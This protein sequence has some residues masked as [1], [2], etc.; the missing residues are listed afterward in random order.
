MLY[1]RKL[2]V[3]IL[4]LYSNNKTFYYIINNEQHYSMYWQVLDSTTPWEN[5][6][7]R[8]I[9]NF[10]T[11]YMVLCF[12]LFYLKNY[13]MVSLYS[14]CTVS[15][16][17][18]CFISGQYGISRRFYFPFQKSYWCGRSSSHDRSDEYL[19]QG[20]TIELRGQGKAF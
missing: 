6:K 3:A 7:E 15:L 13:I 19:Y 17:I 20:S 1:I 14:N 2:P 10:T 12:F 9:V 16:F 5:E 8:V 11:N 4:K 18:H